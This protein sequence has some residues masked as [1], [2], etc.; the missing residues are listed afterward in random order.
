MAI[1]S[2]DE[3]LAIMIENDARAA[4]GLPPLPVRGEPGP[5]PTAIFEHHPA[6]AATPAPA[7]RKKASAADQRREEGRAARERALYD[8]ARAVARDPL[9]TCDDLLAPTLARLADVD[10]RLARG[11][12]HLAAETDPAR[13]ERIEIRLF[14]LEATRISIRYDIALF[15]PTGETRA[16]EIV[17]HHRAG[18]ADQLP[19]APP[20]WERLDAVGPLPPD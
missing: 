8:A 10:A 3:Q 12:E 5:L 4:A 9:A 20:R 1:L 17:R 11:R 15:G 16:Q 19:P 18:T 6:P 2:L 14:V 7:P 13:R